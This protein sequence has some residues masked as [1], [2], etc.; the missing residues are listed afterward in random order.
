MSA[1]RAAPSPSF[2]RSTRTVSETASTLALPR[3]Q[4]LRHEGRAVGHLR[5]AIGQLSQQLD[6]VAIDERDGAQVEGQL[7][8]GAEGFFAGVPQLVYPRPNELPL[9]RQG[10]G[11]VA[12]VE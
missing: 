1:S 2:R 5:P 10:R 7:G 12:I 8:G 9:Q 11:A 4:L 6:A 3:F